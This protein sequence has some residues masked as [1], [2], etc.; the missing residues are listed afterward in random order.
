MLNRRVSQAE[1]ARGTLDRGRMLALFRPYRAR[2][3]AVLFLI[4]VSA[5]LGMVSP[6]L[7]RA[8]LDRAIPDRDS[9]ARADVRRDTL[10]G[11]KPGIMLRPTGRD[12]T[13]VN[14]APQ[15]ARRRD[16]RDRR[17]RKFSGRSRSSGRVLSPPPGVCDEGVDRP[18]ERRERAL[19]RA[20]GAGARAAGEKMSRGR[21]TPMRGRS[22]VERKRGP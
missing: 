17:L 2:L 13:G 22:D 9:R 21:A 10:V 3:A 4:L 7:L 11:V 18:P 16:D 12:T 8:I 19:E 15:H 6:F 14:D 5:A 20:V 1:E